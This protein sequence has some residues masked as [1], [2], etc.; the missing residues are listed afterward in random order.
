MEPIMTTILGLH[1]HK[2]NVWLAADSRECCGDSITADDCDKIVE[3]GRW[4]IA[5]AGNSRGGNLL[6]NY[7][8]RLSECPDIFALSRCLRELLIEDGWSL[9]A[10]DAS[11]GGPTGTRSNGFVVAEPGHL[12]GVMFGG[13]YTDSPRDFCFTMGSGGE[14][15]Q[16][17]CQA[18]LAEG[19]HPEKAI[20]RAM[21]VAASIDTHTGGEIRIKRIPAL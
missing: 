19:F 4:M 12:W 8:S 9:V 11:E 13:A 6:I 5:C 14:I 7:T 10:R 20:L 15:A 3:A 17:A 16:G 1:D 18:L 2:G 21:A